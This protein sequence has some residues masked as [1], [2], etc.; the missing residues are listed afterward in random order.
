MNTDKKKFGMT[1]LGLK[2]GM[3]GPAQISQLQ[4]F[5][6]ELNKD[7]SIAKY[8][9]L[10]INHKKYNNLIMFHLRCFCPKINELLMIKKCKQTLL[11]ANEEKN[12]VVQLSNRLS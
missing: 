11:S 8:V 9:K 12:M 3:H 4:A 6:I 5:Q 10:W 2:P 1:L 7:I